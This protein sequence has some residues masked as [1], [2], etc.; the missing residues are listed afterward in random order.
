MGNVWNCLK[1]SANVPSVLDSTDWIDGAT[2]PVNIASGTAATPIYVAV[3][4]NRFGPNR[5]NA[6]KTGWDANWSCRIAGKRNDSDPSSANY[7]AG[8]T[9]QH[10]YVYYDEQYSSGD[11]PTNYRVDH[12]PTAT[13]WGTADL[14]P[15]FV[16]TY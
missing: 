2:C 15:V 11:P 14:G 10:V 7:V 12:T 6:T 8:Q 3:V 5:A 16:S 9:T 4:A 13:T 1:I